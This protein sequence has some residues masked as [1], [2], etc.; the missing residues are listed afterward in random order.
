MARKLRILLTGGGTG[1]HIYPIIAVAQQLNAWAEKNGIESDL[2]YFGDPGEYKTVLE[3]AKIKIVKIVA[4]KMRRYFSILN[5][6]DFIKFLFSVFQSLFKIYWFMP[7]VAF[8]KGGPGAL[9]VVFASRFYQVPLVVHES[10]AIPGLTNKISARRARVVDLAF[11]SAAQYLKTK[12]Q[13][14]VVG[15]PVREEIAAEISAVQA[16]SSFGFDPQKPLILFLGGSQGSGRINDFVIGN[17]ETLLDRY[18]IL[19]QVGKEKFTEYKL[20]YDFITK[21]SSPNFLAGYKFLD[22]F[23]QNLNEALSAADVVISRAGAG[24]I[25]EIASKG[26]PAILVPFPDA[27]SDHQKENAYRYAESGGAVVIEEENLLPSIFLA[28]VEKILNNPDV[29]K[30]MVAGA[31]DFYQAGAAQRIADH[32]LELWQA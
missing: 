23:D 26:K 20:Q 17:L 27:A 13:V 28:Q 21:N 29:N 16:K 14:N 15:N 3:K 30:K 10:D 9:A 25:F 24:A 12:A 7:D 8:S 5:F 6:L 11:L 4:S 32:I 19:H 31:K 18:Q 22:Y 1:G 2:R